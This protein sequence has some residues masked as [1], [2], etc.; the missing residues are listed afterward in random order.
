MYIVASIFCC[1]LFIGGIII[2]YEIHNAI[3]VDSKEPFLWDEFP[4]EDSTIDS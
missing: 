1:L 2:A 4:S 3:S